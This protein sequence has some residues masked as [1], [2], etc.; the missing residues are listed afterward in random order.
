MFTDIFY[1]RQQTSL[2]LR[3]PHGGLRGLGGLGGL[4]AVQYMCNTRY[5]TVTGH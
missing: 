4:N 5:F 1:Q 3:M 2:I